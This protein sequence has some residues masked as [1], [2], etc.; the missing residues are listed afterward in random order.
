[1][2][3]LRDR[4]AHNIN[5]VTPTH[6]APSIREAILLAR[7]RGLGI[8]VVYNT[9]SVDSVNTL[10][11]LDGCIDVYLPD[12]KYY[13]SS[14]AK[15]LSFFEDYVDTARLAIDEMVR[16]RPTP[17]IENDLIKSGV[18]VRILLLPG[19]LA[20]A[21]LN[22]KYLYEK[23]KNQIYLSLMNQYTPVNKMKPP[24]NRPVTS[25]EYSELVSYA[26][27]IG[28]VNGFI[29]EGGTVSESFI[30]EFNK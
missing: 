12:L 11:M 14:T 19:H 20:E 3:L 15:S 1:M 24:L 27:R 2:L 28:V 5:L 23:Y 10:R 26:E 6:F 18:V 9:S 7:E 17:I 16:Q 29:Q 25:A 8:P 13:K 30:P 22:V 21:K 4:G